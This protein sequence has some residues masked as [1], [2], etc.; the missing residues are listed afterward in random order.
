MPKVVA[1]TRIINILSKTSKSSNLYLKS[2]K[3]VISSAGRNVTKGIDCFKQQAKLM[4]EYLTDIEK[5]KRCIINYY[6][7]QGEGIVS[8]TVK[9]NRYTNGMKNPEVNYETN[10]YLLN[11]KNNFNMGKTDI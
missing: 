10:Q 2:A 3:N 5:F 1:L 11:P 9:R 4:L 8:Q 6:K 7:N